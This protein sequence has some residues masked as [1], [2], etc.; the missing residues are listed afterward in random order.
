MKYC[1]KCILPDTRP[2]LL[3]GSDGICNACKNHDKKPN[4]N[5]NSRAQDFKKLVEHVVKTSDSYDC[6]IPVSGGKDSTWQTKVCLDHGLTPLAVTWATPARTEIGQKNLE[7]LI[8]LGVDHIDYRINPKVEKTF[9]WKAFQ[10]HGSTAL[11][12][13]MAIFS[14]PQNIAVKFKIPL[15][16]Y[17][18]NSAFEYGDTQNATQGFEM[19]AEWLKKFGV[20]AG[21]GPE[22]WLQHGFRK[23]ELAGYKRP[24]AQTLN[25]HNIRAIFLGQYFRWDPEDVKNFAN[26]I[27]FQFQ[28]GKRKTGLYDYA[29]IDDDFISVHHWMKWYKFG[30][31]RLFDNLSLEIR[32][33][34]ITREDAINKVIELGDQTPYE[35][36]EKCC[37]FMEV[38]T[39]QFYKV[40]E[41]FRNHAIWTKQGDKWLIKDF[42]IKNWEW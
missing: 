24:T 15:I 41:K 5:W 19:N 21:T 2:N 23:K 12:M 29:D 27:G 40:A 8:S 4:I 13:H 10:L 25:E 35:D 39:E 18:E 31:T 32:N 42:I 3:I 17:G 9:M 7:N 33:Q 37:E 1:K 14:I 6:L 20:T 34:R 30:F 36:I 22:D 26:K 11:P 16:I 38:N 28:D